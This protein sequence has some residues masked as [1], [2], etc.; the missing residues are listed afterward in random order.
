M[1]ILLISCIPNISKKIYHDTEENKLS[2]EHIGGLVSVEL[3]Q[4][5]EQLRPKTGN[6][7]ASFVLFILLIRCI[8]NVSN[9]LYHGT[10]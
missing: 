4:I 6:P 9:K 7:L 8:P 1:S 2:A 5:M 3:C 10:G